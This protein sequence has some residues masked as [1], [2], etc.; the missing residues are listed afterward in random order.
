MI[1]NGTGRNA[2]CYKCMKHFCYCEDEAGGSSLNCCYM[3][4]DYCVDCVP[5]GCAICTNEEVCA[6]CLINVMAVMEPYVQIATQ[7]ISVVV[8]KKCTVQIVT[9]EGSLML[10]VANVAGKTTAP[11]AGT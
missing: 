3:S 5:K 4:K 1:Q 6:K 7:N 2:I 9:M 8:A 11:I 10:N